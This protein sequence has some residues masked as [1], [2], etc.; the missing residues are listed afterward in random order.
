MSFDSPGVNSLAQLSALLV[1]IGDTLG[2]VSIWNF[3]SGSMVATLTAASQIN[4]ILMYQADT[5]FVGYQN[6]E[7]KRWRWTTGKEIVSSASCGP[8]PITLMYALHNGNI[9]AQCGYSNFRYLSSS[10]VLQSDYNSSTSSEFQL[11]PNSNLVFRC[12]FLS[13]KTIFLQNLEKKI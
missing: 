12:K 4:S 1:A 2:K 5:V 8:L 9:L 6:G 13:I 11:L 3:V 7:I 10:L